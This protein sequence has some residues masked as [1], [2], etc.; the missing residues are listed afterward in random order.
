MRFVSGSEEEG[1]GNVSL[2]VKRG[3][4]IQLMGTGQYLSETDGLPVLV[5]GD[6]PS[7]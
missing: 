6:E 2:A 4:L 1:S 3:Q 5:L 7:P